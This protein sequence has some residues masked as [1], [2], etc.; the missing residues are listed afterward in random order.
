MPGQPD[1]R[2]QLV[3]C[4]SAYATHAC[5]VTL[6]A[7]SSASWFV[8]FANPFARM[9]VASRCFK[10][11]TF[12]TALCSAD[13]SSCTC[14]GCVRNLCIMF[15][16]DAKS[17]HVCRM[18]PSCLLVSIW[19]SKRNYVFLESARCRRDCNCRCIWRMLR[20]RQRKTRNNISIVCSL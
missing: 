17:R 16:R 3:A 14:S 8:A 10:A 7:R 5:C 2:I 15:A 13:S 12:Y 11:L 20:G 4:A 9:C 6:R 19:R 1:S 18:P